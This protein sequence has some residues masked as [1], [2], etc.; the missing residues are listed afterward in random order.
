MFQSPLFWM[1]IMMTCLISSVSGSVAD[2]GA[3]VSTSGACF[4]TK[5]W[6]SYGCFCG[7]GSCRN[8]IAVDCL[9]SCCAQH[10]YCYD[11]RSGQRGLSNL[12]VLVL[13]YNWRRGRNNRIQCLDC[14]RGGNKHKCKKCVCDRK[15]TY[16]LRGKP[17][18]DIFHRYK[19]KE[20]P[21]IRN[22]P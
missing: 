1:F 18:P 21:A 11:G 13:S 19:N 8:Q 10:D 9:D 15:L 3:M 5:L 4:T 16:C 22:R 2:L 7:L 6:K 17:C 12:E 20:C 14:G